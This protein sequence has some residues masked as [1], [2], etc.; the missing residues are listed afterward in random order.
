MNLP[1]GGR[2][3]HDQTEGGKSTLPRITFVDKGVDNDTHAPA[4]GDSPHKKARANGATA[5]PPPAGANQPTNGRAGKPGGGRGG[6]PER[7]GTRVPGRDGAARRSRDARGR[8]A[9]GAE[10]S[11]ATEPS[12]GRERDPYPTEL[13]AGA[14]SP[15]RGNPLCLQPTRQGN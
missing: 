13:R 7:S 10:R 6:A 4:A 3:T 2:G 12:K 15:P 9:E 8:R 14:S 5:L 11:E 1:M